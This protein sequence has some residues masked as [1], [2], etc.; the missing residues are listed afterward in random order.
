M[1]ASVESENQRGARDGKSK[2]VKESVLYI[3]Y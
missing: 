3:V 1:F 2:Q